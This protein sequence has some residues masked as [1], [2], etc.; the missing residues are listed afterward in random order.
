MKRPLVLIGL[1]SLFVPALAWGD[2]MMF[3]LTARD[4]V[5]QKAQQAWIDW[6]DG[7]ERLVI[8]VDPKRSSSRAAWVVPIPAAAADARLKLD[9]RLPEWHGQEVRAGALMRLRHVSVVFIL[10]WFLL[11]LPLPVAD[12]PRDSQ[13]GFTRVELAIV[14]AILWVLASISIGPGGS[15]VS[16]TGVR[17]YAHFE[18][19]GLVSELVDA[20]DADSL[21]RYLKGKSAGLPP[22]ALEPL[23]GYFG[24]QSCFVV[25]WTT[26]AVL[27]QGL[28]LDVSFPSPQPYYPMK[29][30][31]IYGKKDLAADVMVA[32][33]WDGSPA[34]MRHDRIKVGY[35]RG[36][37][38]D[39]R[40]T[41]FYFDGPAGEL[42]EDWSFQPRAS[43]R[44]LELAVLADT[45]AYF[46]NLALY[47]AA[48]LA[49]TLLAGW[50]ALPMP[51]GPWAILHWLA[52][53]LSQA[54]PF[55]GPRLLLN[56]LY[57]GRDGWPIRARIAFWGLPVIA[58]VFFLA[59]SAALAG[60][61]SIER[62]PVRISRRGGDLIM[63][64][65]IGA[66]KTNLGHIRSA[67]SVYYGD[68]EGVNPADLAAL[69]RDGRYLKGLPMVKLPHLH[70]NSAA[71]RNMTIAE[72]EREEFTDEGGW[73]YVNE[74][75][76]IGNIVVNCTHTDYRGA[77]FASY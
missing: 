8:L 14:I 47:A 3:G 2:G 60:L 75:P 49:A 23:R 56:R 21:G 36:W 70:P 38:D 62:A 77:V 24:P 58:C 9:E 33:W 1:V 51:A 16:E 63:K 40:F 41:R 76:Q 28:A 61:W 5:G 66:T 45:S 59:G 35:Y 31:S 55:I 72:F 34:M 17:T 52:L 4:L 48:A 37:G 7:Q 27:A 73:A 65:N 25:S 53:W 18:R 12:G 42:T 6:K 57:L 64:S 11:L 67:L 26:A 39:K 44:D 20:P 71:V 74:G 29:L 54:L 50:A 10:L 69:T 32:G 22:E 15:T 30:S 46:P 19:G 43:N 13:Q 68:T